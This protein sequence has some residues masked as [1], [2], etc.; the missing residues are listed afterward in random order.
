M[1]NE[2]KK[3]PKNKKYPFLI[4][5]V[6]KLKR[7]QTPREVVGEIVDSPAVYLCRHLDREGIATA[8]SFVPTVLRPWVLDKF[9]SY[10]TIKDLYLTYTFP[11]RM[12]KGKAFTAIVGRLAARGTHYAVKKLNGIPVYRGEQSAKV[13]TT[14]KTSV[15]ALEDGDS[16]VVFPDVDYA[17]KGA[18]DEQ[19]Y[20]GFGV[21]DKMYRRKTGKSLAFV[22]VYID[23]KSVVLHKPVYFDGSDEKFYAD[24]AH[25]MYRRE[26][27]D[28][29][30][31]TAAPEKKRNDDK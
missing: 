6:A 10:E 3:R 19:I 9:T 7:K 23:E 11:V 1:K 18:G 25:G 24:V 22:P 4:R 26:E 21:V 16:L 8:I 2:R 30:V 20:K 5:F 15:R 29:S 27:L 28:G 12:G 17:D 13:V 14:I 31:L